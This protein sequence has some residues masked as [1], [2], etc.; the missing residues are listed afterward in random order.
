[1]AD[2]QAAPRQRF[3]RVIKF[4]D[5]QSGVVFARRIAG[6]GRKRSVNQQRHAAEIPHGGVRAVVMG[7][8]AEQALIELHVPVDIINEAGD[9]TRPGRHHRVAGAHDGS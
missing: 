2:R 7:R 9:F 6:A 5:R 3:D 4:I 8:P 1:M